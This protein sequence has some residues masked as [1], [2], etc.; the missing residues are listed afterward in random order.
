MFNGPLTRAQFQSV[1]WTF[2]DNNRLQIIPGKSILNRWNGFES[3]EGIG[4]W[5][6]RFDPAMLLSPKYSFLDIPQ[7]L[8]N[9]FHLD[10]FKKVM[11]KLDHRGVQYMCDLHFVCG[12]LHDNV[13]DIKKFGTMK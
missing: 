4:F 5:I 12:P 11:V 13:Y 9:F 10:A 7:S 8:C 6:S 1:L 3:I 2:R